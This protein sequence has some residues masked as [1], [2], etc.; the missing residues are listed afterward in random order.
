MDK[1]DQIIMRLEVIEQEAKL[2]RGLLTI[3]LALSSVFMLVH[4]M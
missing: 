4:F 1:E 2:I 3:L